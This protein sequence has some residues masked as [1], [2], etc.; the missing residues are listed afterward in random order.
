MNDSDML[1]RVYIGQEINCSRGILYKFKDE[2]LFDEEENNAISSLLKKSLISENQPYTVKSIITLITTKAGKEEA[3]RLIDEILKNSV[4]LINELNEIP[5]KAVGFLTIN[6]EEHLFQ[7]NEEEFFFSWEDFVLNRS[8]MFNY[9]IKLCKMLET[10]K[11]AVLT[12]DYVSSHGGRVD[13]EKYVIPDEVVEFITKNLHPSPFEYDETKQALL[14]FTIYEIGNDI[15]SIKEEDRRRNNYW[16]L[17]RGLP[18]DESAIKILINEFRD[19][20]IT[21]EYSDIKNEHFL[22]SILDKS[23][24]KIKLERMLNTFVTK[25]IEGKKVDLETL[26]KPSELLTTHSEL[27][28]TIGNFEMRFREGIIKEMRATCKENKDGW[29]DQLKEN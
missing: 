8:K 25:T 3:K 24:F 1:L 9:A 17:L 20:K 22:F 27:F 14:L 10:H 11:L 28:A 21:T 16:N 29:Y 18:F 13:P 15:L 5:K 26:T 4:T 2:L 7:Q 19:E 6:L 12:T 23:R